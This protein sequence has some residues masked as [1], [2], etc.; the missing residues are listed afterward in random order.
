MGKIY[1]L[2]LDSFSVYLW[3]QHPTDPAFAASEV[4]CALCVVCDVHAVWGGTNSPSAA[5]EPYCLVL[6]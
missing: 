1:F 6:L 4:L 2:L 5:T 3:L